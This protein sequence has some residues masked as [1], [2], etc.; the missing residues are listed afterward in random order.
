MEDGKMVELPTGE[1]AVDRINGR[2]THE[3]ETIRYD[4]NSMEDG[5][6]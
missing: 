1:D 6:I 5:P 2:S 4:R 3:R